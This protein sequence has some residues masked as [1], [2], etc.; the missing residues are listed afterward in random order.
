MADDAPDVLKQKFIEADKSAKNFQS[1]W[2]PNKKGQ[3]QSASAVH[4]T[5]F[6]GGKLLYW[7]GN[8]WILGAY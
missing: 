7:R 8:D 3:I 5:A 1:N 2:S 6:D 4:A